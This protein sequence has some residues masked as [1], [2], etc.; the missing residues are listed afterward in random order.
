[1]K[2]SHMKSSQTEASLQW[3][4]EWLDGVA[5]GSRTMSQRRLSSIEKQGGG[6]EVIK[7]LAEQR[8]VH[9]LRLEDDEGDALVA[10][11]LKPFEVLC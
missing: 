9:L 2:S 4:T 3:A 1:M 10:A 7:A 8:G 11:S 5:D 6:L